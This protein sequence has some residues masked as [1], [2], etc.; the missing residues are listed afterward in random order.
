[1]NKSLFCKI[2]N[3]LVPLILNENTLRSICGLA[4]LNETTSKAVATA[5]MDVKYFID[6]KDKR[7][8]NQAIDELQTL[9]K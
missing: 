5:I 4:G 9:I 7:Y 3:F 8:V 1:M 6:T 2:R